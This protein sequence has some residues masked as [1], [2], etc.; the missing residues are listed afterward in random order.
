MVLK[1]AI[2]DV[3]IFHSTAFKTKPKCNFGYEIKPSGSP[4]FRVSGAQHKQKLKVT[5]K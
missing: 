4:G 1:M 3:Q 5:A 2:N